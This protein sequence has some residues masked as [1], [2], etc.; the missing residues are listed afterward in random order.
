MVGLPFNK[1]ASVIVA[2]TVIVSPG[3]KYVLFGE[4]D[5]DIAGAVLSESKFPIFLLQDY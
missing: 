4:I 5:V 2:V 3:E 1:F